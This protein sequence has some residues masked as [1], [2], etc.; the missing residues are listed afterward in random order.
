LKLCRQPN[1][2]QQT[3]DNRT[4]HK[5]TS[6]QH[7]LRQSNFFSAES[8]QK[9]MG[10]EKGPLSDFK[11]KRQVRAFRLDEAIEIFVRPPLECQMN[12]TLSLGESARKP[13]WICRRGLR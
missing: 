8:L 5:R 7:A 10:P 6:Y 13:P 11:G 12:G 9:K 3:S 1:F 4:S 2:W